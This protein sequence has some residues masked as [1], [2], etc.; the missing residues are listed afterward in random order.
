VLFDFDRREIPDQQSLDVLIDVIETVSTA[1][2]GRSLCVSYEGGGTAMW[3][4]GRQGEFAF[5]EGQRPGGS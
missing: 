4:I 3:Y 1:T 2:G 5:P